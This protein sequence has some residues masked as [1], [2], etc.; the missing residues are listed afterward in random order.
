MFKKLLY[1]VRINYMS[2]NKIFNICVYMPEEY[3]K[4]YT[5]CP[6]LINLG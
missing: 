1:K 5:L 4:K 6:P 2:D 3:K